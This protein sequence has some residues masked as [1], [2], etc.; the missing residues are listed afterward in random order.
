MTYNPPPLLSD[1]DIFLFNEGTHTRLYE[2]LGAQIRADGTH[3]AVWAPDAV[4][5]SVVGDFNGWD[6]ESHQMLPTEAGIWKVIAPE[7]VCRCEPQ[8]Q[9]L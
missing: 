9:S 1:D 4:A 5:V 6:P 8:L 7:K 2:H 3:F